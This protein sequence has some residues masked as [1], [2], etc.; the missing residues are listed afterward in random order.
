MTNDN[1]ARLDALRQEAAKQASHPP[2]ARVCSRTAF[3]VQFD[4][5]RDW[6]KVCHFHANSHV[7]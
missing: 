5:L 7:Y 2:T 3:E 1:N 6:C 4:G